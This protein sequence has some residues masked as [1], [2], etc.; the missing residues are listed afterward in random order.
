M[1]GRNQVSSGR[2]VGAG[3]EGLLFDVYGAAGRKRK[4]ANFWYRILCKPDFLTASESNTIRVATGRATRRES[5]N[6]IAVWF[7]EPDVAG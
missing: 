2:W 6:G 5:T 1:V 3:T 4:A 7:G